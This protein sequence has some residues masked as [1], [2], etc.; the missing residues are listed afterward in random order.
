MRRS[1]CS[2]LAEL[3]TRTRTRA[4]EEAAEETHTATVPQG[5]DGVPL[6]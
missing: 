3:L 6:R 4:R 1:I 2:S 5:S